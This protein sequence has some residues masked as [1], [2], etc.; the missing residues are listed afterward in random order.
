MD[1]KAVKDEEWD[2][3]AGIL[4]SVCKDSAS[5]FSP[6][7]KNLCAV[8]AIEKEAKTEAAQG[9]PKE[10]EGKTVAAQVAKNSTDPAADGSK[11]APDEEKTG[12]EGKE[13]RYKG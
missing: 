3:S 5:V 1:Q 6:V 9:P 4:F 10:E 11:I 13:A 7:C 8:T 12:G 2:K